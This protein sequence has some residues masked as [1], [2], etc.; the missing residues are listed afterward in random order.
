MAVAP[1]AW[2]DIS[3]DSFAHNVTHAAATLAE[4]SALMVAV[5]SDAYGHGIDHIA[6]VA[7]A[8]GATAL[9]VLDVATG[10]AL[11]PTL[12]HTPLLAWLLSPGCDFLSASHAG[13]TL[14]IS[15]LWQLEKLAAECGD[16]RTTV[17][18]KID[19]GLHRNGALARDWPAL[20]HYAK[21]LSDAGVITVEGVWSHL[22]DTSLD[23]DRL[24]LR[25]FS[26][27]VAIVRA[28]G[29]KPSVL[30]IAASAAAT[31]LPEARLDMVRVGISAYGVSPFDDRSA[32]DM[33]FRPVMSAHALITEVDD[34]NSR[35]RGA[36]GFADGLFPIPPGVGWAIVGDHKV[37]IESVEVDHVVLSIPEGVIINPGDVVTLWGRPDKGSPRAEDWAEWAS[38]IG[39][40]IVTAMSPHLH[41]NFL[42][43]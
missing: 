19:T 22:A 12:P 39:D 3:L 24:A 21:E 9:A 42:S 14:G 32:E 43:D 25:R 6:P 17:H 1:Q 36:M 10:V 11:R 23:E 35:A 30:H 28:A 18:L 29:L 37:G 33:G 34:E 16:L 20:V 31:D 13:V 2:L 8:S 40:E 7:V 15:H 4:G 5:K 27:A 38:T 41:R 26:D